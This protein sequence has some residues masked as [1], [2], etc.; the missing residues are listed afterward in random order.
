MTDY[1]Y[2]VTFR[3]QGEMAK[4][5]YYA[6]YCWFQPTKKGGL[7]SDTIKEGY[8]VIQLDKEFPLHDGV[9]SVPTMKNTTSDL[10]LKTPS[11]RPP[12]RRPAS[13]SPRSFP[14]P[15]SHRHARGWQAGQVFS[16]VQPMA[17]AYREL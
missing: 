11:F 3:R 10:L 2:V 16:V 13:R 4:W 17:G 6:G 12:P 5:E 8:W 9:Y 7:F 15:A 14:V 1:R